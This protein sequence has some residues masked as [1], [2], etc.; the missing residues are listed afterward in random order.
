[1]GAAFEYPQTY[2]IEFNPLH[3]VPD[4]TK[5]LFS[6]MASGRAWGVRREARTTRGDL[7]AQIL[8]RT[9]ERQ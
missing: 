4:V 2:P 8:N 1:M 7:S 9:D 6:A 3:A 5:A